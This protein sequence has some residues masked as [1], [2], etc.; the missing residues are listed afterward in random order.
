MYRKW[1]LVL[2]F[3]LLS[4]MALLF[5]IYQSENKYVIE[6][7]LNLRLGEVVNDQ[8]EK[9]TWLSN[10]T[11]NTVEG[12]STNITKDDY[13]LFAVINN[14]VVYWS[15]NAYIPEYKSFNSLE[16]VSVYLDASGYSIV[17]RLVKKPSALDSIEYYSF[18]PVT[19]RFENDSH[20][21][22]A[23]VIPELFPNFNVRISEGGVPL[24]ID[25][26]VLFRVDAKIKESR[27]LSV[28]IFIF[29]IVISSLITLNLFMDKLIKKQP[30]WT[31]VWAL[32]LLAGWFYFFRQLF[33]EEITLPVFKEIGNQ[34]GLFLLD[35]SE[36]IIIS[37]LFLLLIVC[38][39][40]PAVYKSKF[41]L[42]FL[43]R[44]EKKWMSSAY[45]FLAMMNSYGFYRGIELLSVKV[46][47][48][49]D[50]TKSLLFNL[51]KVEYYITLL[52]MA[53]SYFL[54]NHFLYK[55][56]LKSLDIIKHLPYLIIVLIVYAVLPISSNLWV[57]IPHSLSWLIMYYTG[58]AVQLSNP[59][60]LTLFYFMVI[61]MSTS[62]IYA[63]VIYKIDRSNEISSKRDF[64]LDLITSHDSL[65]VHHINEVIGK[66]KNNKVIKLRFQ[67]EQLATTNIK[68]QITVLQDPYLDLYDFEIHL[69]NSRGTPYGFSKASNEVFSKD[70]LL[71][72][73]RTKFEN[74]FLITHI[75]SGRHKYYAVVNLMN[76]QEY[77]GQ[78]ILEYTKRRFFPQ[79]VF[80]TFLNSQVLAVDNIK[81]YDYAFYESGLLLHRFGN[82]NFPDSLSIIQPIPITLNEH[83]FNIN[84]HRFF[85][86]KT[87]NTRCL[88]LVS[89]HYP[90][91]AMISNVAFMFILTFIGFGLVFLI[92]INLKPIE[93][94]SLINKIQLYVGIAFLV[95]TLLVSMAI[96]NV[97]NTSY[98]A[99]INRSYQNKALNIAENMTDELEIFLNN[100]INRDQFNQKLI[101]MSRLTQS[102]L[103]IYSA[104]GKWLGA[105]K[106]A[107]FDRKIWS[108]YL[109]RE[110]INHI[111]VG[112]GQLK[113]VADRAGD[114][115]F[116]TVYTA[117]Y[118]HEAGR[119]LGVL[120]IPFFDSTRNNNLQQIEVF[121]NLIVFFTSIFLLTLIVGYYGMRKIISPIQLISDSMRHTNIFNQ[122]PLPL[123]YRQKDE[124]GMLVFEYNEMVSKLEKSKNELALVQKEAAWKEIAQQVAHEIKNPLTPMK[125]KIQQMQ[126]HANRSSLDYEVLNSLLAQ[127]ENLASIADS[128]SAF[129][130]MPAP[131][132]EVFDFSRLLKQILSLFEDNNMEIE[133][134]QSEKLFVY[135][136]SDLMRQILNNLILNAIQ[137]VK[138]NEIEIKVVL[139]RKEDQLLLSIQDNGQGIE[140]INSANIFKPYFSTK[141]RGSGIGLALAK[142]GIEQ[143]R[144]NIWFEPNTGLGTTFFVSLPLAN[145]KL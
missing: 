75:E 97:L 134:D 27:E 46:G 67:N 44:K 4:G 42:D 115:N 123:S 38:K 1:V 59:K 135:A 31:L 111:L 54:I 11:V 15:S 26:K 23:R 19:R 106:S 127:I 93:K 136:D 104:T 63:G 29:L 72:S 53:A 126:R 10:E 119:L 16:A 132:N 68:E 71:L 51:S 58:C 105:N 142:K 113:I 66:V 108:K 47:M 12:V 117:I 125:L 52:I 74:I 45:F 78:L 73:E 37:L 8:F 92:M 41:F 83:S 140:L 116:N 133:I 24:S 50:I 43:F 36:G 98:R 62:L 6:E 17:L 5:S 56:F 139:V 99:D 14:E 57:L 69:F 21:A 84:D 85:Q 88:L 33:K 96:M 18:I 20:D 109:N 25:N 77:L 101:E 120:A 95:P 86:V 112:Q 64:A 141:M 131:R 90:R 7:R 32:P 124:I 94:Y 49:I 82:Y 102:D 13:P 100:Q 87:S 30:K 107:L 39:L 35:I 130:Q 103:M 79:T 121:N 89:P 144:G 138:S 34:R 55:I 80:T 28:A 118:G 143:A 122:G 110:A 22:I 40:I 65:A 61:A 145:S 91:N 137:S 2:F 70:Q 9:L 128:F 3:W 60:Y 81:S 114:F 76:G 48:E 129:A